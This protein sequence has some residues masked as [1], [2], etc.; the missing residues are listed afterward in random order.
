MTSVLASCQ[1][2]PTTFVVPFSAPTTIDYALGSGPYTVT[3]DA[4]DLGDCS[5]TYIE[6]LA[7][8]SMSWLSIS[9]RTIT[10]S[11]T[12]ASLES[13]TATFTVTSTLSGLSTP[14]TNSNLVITVSFSDPCKTAVLQS[15]S[16][17]ASISV[18]DGGHQTEDFTDASDSEGQ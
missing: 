18:A 16:D 9:G 10:I 7:V 14:T 11:S 5:G 13:T 17:I 4:Y 6:T 15:P 3:L 8:D 1:D 12:E 2:P